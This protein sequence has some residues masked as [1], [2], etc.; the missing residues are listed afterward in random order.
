MR[1]HLLLIAASC[2]LA[3]PLVADEFVMVSRLGSKALRSGL[4][5][6]RAALAP[7]SRLASTHTGKY[8]RWWDLTSGELTATRA[9]AAARRDVILL[10]VSHNGRDVLLGGLGKSFL[11][12]QAKG[13]PVQ[14]PGR[15]TVGFELVPP[16]FSPCGGFLAHLDADGK[17]I[18]VRE[19]AT[20]RV[21]ARI[22]LPDA[23]HPPALTF[24]NE[25]ELTVWCGGDLRRYGLDG[26]SR[27]RRTPELPS[28]RLGGARFSPDSEYLAIQAGGEVVVV[29]CSDLSSVAVGAPI[30]APFAVSD[31]HLAIADNDSHVIYVHTHRMRQRRAFPGSRAPL[32][33]LDFSHNGRELLGQTHCRLHMWDVESGQQKPY[34][35][36][37]E[38]I[39]TIRFS[40]ANRLYCCDAFGV[41]ILSL[42]DGL[43]RDIAS[44]GMEPLD[45]SRGVRFLR[46]NGSVGIGGDRS[47]PISIEPWGRFRHIR[48]AASDVSNGRWAIVGS[49]DGRSP[50]VCVVDS[51]DLA[52][53]AVQIPTKHLRDTLQVA[54]SGNQLALD[55]EDS[56]DVVNWRTSK[57][58]HRIQLG[59]SHRAFA[60]VSEAAGAGLV[61][62]SWKDK[63]ATGRLAIHSLKGSR[64]VDKALPP[65]GTRDEAAP[66]RG[67][68][69][70]A[71]STGRRF[72]LSV[73]N[74]LRAY[75]VALG[76][77][78]TMAA[79]AGIESVAWSPSGSTV[80]IG[81]TDTT[82]AVLKY[83]VK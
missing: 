53:H 74:E 18:V 4:Y 76:R 5:Y 38:F 49:A 22:P 81:L 35:E 67:P 30:G 78:A 39:G 59:T 27:E 23:R 75:D 7:G 11:L 57:T 21:A 10:Q 26:Q 3:R 17:Q 66:I 43:R 33:K 34:S 1:P 65:I 72:L 47:R 31:Q 16:A 15:V 12:Q 62:A 71:D 58:L 9:Y 29:R 42:K 54:L 2:L 36:G 13:Q 52:A 73:G 25:N 50:A 69:V 45:T 44:G 51:A 6:P 46:R 79:P 41:R 68:Q 55:R 8:V 83:S 32:R 77:V 56:V 37:L 63:T 24:A 40:G 19:L 28:E 60:F 64:L 61:L 20:T 70:S 80:A 82:I 48:C 14:L